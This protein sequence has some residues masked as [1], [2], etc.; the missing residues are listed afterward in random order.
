[1]AT[2]GT[3]AEVQH[4]LMALFPPAVV[5][6]VTRSVES[7]L[8][9]ATEGRDSLMQLD[10][11]T[12]RAYAVSAALPSR[13]LQSVVAMRVWQHILF[14]N[15]PTHA[16][17]ICAAFPLPDDESKVQPKGK[18]QKRGRFPVPIYVRRAFE[19]SVF[20]KLSKPLRNGTSNH[21]YHHIGQT[22]STLACEALCS[23]YARCDAYTWFNADAPSG[24]ANSC[25]AMTLKLTGWAPSTSQVA[26]SGVK[27]LRAGLNLITPRGQLI[28]KP[29]GQP[30]W[31]EPCTRRME[32]LPG[33]LDVGVIRAGLAPISR[34]DEPHQCHHACYLSKYC[35]R[36][37]W[38][39]P[40]GSPV[41]QQ[42]C[43]HLTAEPMANG[44]RAVMLNSRQTSTAKKAAFAQ[45]S[46]HSPYDTLAQRLL[47]SGQLSELAATLSRV[48]RNSSITLVT[49]HREQLPLARQFLC[50]LKRWSGA[51]TTPFLWLCGD[52]S[53]CAFV[54][55]HRLQTFSTKNVRAEGFLLTWRIRI[56]LCAV[57]LG[58]DV[59]I[60]DPGAVWLQD[61]WPWL[62]GPFDVI[63]SPEQRLGE[64]YG[65][66]LGADFFC[67]R[68]TNSSVNLLLRLL[69]RVENT[70]IQSVRE[71]ASTLSD[72]LNDLIFIGMSAN[73]TLI[74]GHL[75]AQYRRSEWSELRVKVLDG[76]AFPPAQVS[77][78]WWAAARRA[79][80][81]S[82]LVVVRT[83]TARR[84]G[85]RL[86]QL[87]G[88][89]ASLSSPSTQRVEEATTGCFAS[90][91]GP[92]VRRAVPV[93]SV[94][95]LSYGH[96]SNVPTLC[97]SLLTC[98]QNETTRLV[99]VSNSKQ[100]YALQT[101]IVEDGSKDGSP[102]AWR[103]G[104]SRPREAGVSWM[105]RSGDVEAAVAFPA[106][107]RNGR[108]AVSDLL[109]FAPNQHE[110]RSYHQGFAMSWGDVLVTLQDDELYREGDPARS[111]RWLG[112]ALKL[113][114]LHP[115]LSMISC[116]AGFLRTAGFACDM[117]DPRYKEKCCYINRTSGCWGEEIA[118]IP[119]HDPRLPGVPFM[120]TAG[121]NFG[122]F[123]VRRDA[124]F[125]L[126]AFDSSWSLVGDPGIG[127]DI[128]F[129]LR[130]Q[131]R[132]DLV[133]IMQCDGIE[134]RVGGGSSLSSPAKRHLR[135]VM[136]RRNNMRLDKLYFDDKPL[137]HQ[138][139]TQAMREN[140]RRL[141]GSL[142]SIPTD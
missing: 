74:N 5:D 139:V 116:N 133:G 104:L 95:M 131:Q 50:E 36:S 136:E 69:E 44:R 31:R 109:L 114:E 125:S 1:M 60:T 68:S 34:T 97:R 94:V 61:P 102:E 52:A 130:A 33:K 10:G 4:E 7:V 27:V 134:R 67:A 24:W 72:A 65:F 38:M 13:G 142:P 123:I 29:A 92:V 57:L 117:F 75:G 21:G 101:I 110:I 42:A 46:W 3:A 17:Q 43:F 77:M 86:Q 16:S 11:V 105:S 14:A 30:P 25:I 108:T 140:R 113:F 127:Y 39:N 80:F 19:Q 112:D 71:A 107:P 6:N 82:R 8:A 64:G 124:Y 135:Y 47:D 138:F 56:S 59:L 55:E 119:M 87:K 78:D 76:E 132:G 118:P 128:E 15:V 32:V 91:I 28:A 41:L 18:R 93:I 40:K 58:Y 126:G 106:G 120:F 111:R 35:D 84:L 73:R 45:P 9:V 129:S 22:G 100:A 54:D 121:V 53:A 12:L 49:L 37:V 79:D 51:E 115:D 63:A 83:E 122:P 103:K 98:G 141:A 85:V 137:M 81:L 70:R 99:H 88:I 26:T 2:V 20:A 62:A 23:S 96:A 89:G 66:P 90:G 48:S